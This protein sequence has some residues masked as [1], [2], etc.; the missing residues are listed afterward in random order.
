MIRFTKTSKLAA[1]ALAGATLLTAVPAAA[2]G[3]R[4]PGWRGPGWGGPG[5]YYGPRRHNNGAAVAAGIIGGLAVGAI[6]AGAANNYYR[7]SCWMETR[8]LYNSWGQPY[9]RDVRVCR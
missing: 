2:D 9:Y 6:A 5:Y 8:T 4:G 1:L 3:W 7:P